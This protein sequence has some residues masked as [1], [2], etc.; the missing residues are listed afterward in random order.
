MLQNDTKP[1]FLQYFLGVIG[2]E[3]TTS[4]PKRVHNV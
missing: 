4:F 2:V 3:P 1:G